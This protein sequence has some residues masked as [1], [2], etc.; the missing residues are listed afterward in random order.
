[1][2]CESQESSKESV[3]MPSVN[4][5]AGGPGGDGGGGGGAG[6]GGG[7]GG[8]GAGGGEVVPIFIVTCFEIVPPG[9]VHES[10]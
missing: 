6:G 5:P 8:G 7:G 1:M 2:Y 9:P 4:P 10:E 3:T